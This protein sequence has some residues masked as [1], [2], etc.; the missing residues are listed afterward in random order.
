LLAQA[1]EHLGLIGRLRTERGVA[2]LARHHPPAAVGR[3]QRGDAQP[4][5]GPEHDFGA[6]ARRRCLAQRPGVG[7]AQS[8]QRPRDGL[9]VIDDDK[10]RKPEPPAEVATP[11]APLPIGERDLLAVD[12]RRD[13][14]RRRARARAGLVEVARHRR[15][16]IGGGVVLDHQDALRPPRRIGERKPAFAAADIGEKCGTHWHCASSRS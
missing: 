2:A 13:R 11:E 16:E 8:R 4:G 7:R 3:Y 5:A 15:L 1:R 6:A 9:E 10:R 14:E 12:R